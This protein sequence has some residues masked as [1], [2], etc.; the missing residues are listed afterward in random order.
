MHGRV[1]GSR[2]EVW[3]LSL[4]SPPAAH[5]RS[6]AHP[7][8]LA[9]SRRAPAPRKRHGELMFCQGFNSS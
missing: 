1:G 8:C 7:G 3:V 9:I 2:K 6:T 4:V 5:P